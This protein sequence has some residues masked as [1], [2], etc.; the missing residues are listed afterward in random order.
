M[1]NPKAAPTGHHRAAFFKFPRHEAAPGVAAG[2]VKA[3]EGS[4][5]GL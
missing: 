4:E 1:L 3:E 5:E 2:Q